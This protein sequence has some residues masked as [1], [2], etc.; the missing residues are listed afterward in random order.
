M[1][2]FG[3]G[4]DTSSLFKLWLTCMRIQEHYVDPEIFDGLR[5]EKMRGKEGE[6]QSKHSL[7]SLD[8]DYLL[9]GHGRHAWY[10]YL[11]LVISEN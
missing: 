8:L 4:K 9:F 3:P 6:P 5:F 1:Y 7:V 11:V 2:S 10:A